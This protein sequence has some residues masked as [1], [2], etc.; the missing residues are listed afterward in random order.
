MTE[1]EYLGLIVSKNRIQISEEKIAALKAYKVPDSHQALMRFLGFANYLSAFVPHYAATPRRPPSLTDLLKGGSGKKTKFIWTASCQQAFDSLKDKLTK[2]VGLGIPDKRGDLVLETDA[3][4]VGIGAVLYQF[5]NGKLT[6][7]WFLSRKLNKAEKNYSSRDREALA[8]VYALV[9]ME[10]YLQ[11]KPFI[12]YSDHESLIYFQSQK[13]LKGRDW[14]WVEILA[15][16]SFEQRYRKGETMVAPDALSRAFDDRADPIGAWTE[17]E[18]TREARLHPQVD[19]LNANV[20]IHLRGKLAQKDDMT[21]VPVSHIKTDL[22][23]ADVEVT[24]KGNG[25][26]INK[27]IQ[28]LLDEDSCWGKLPAPVRANTPLARS[29]AGQDAHL[30]SITARVFGDLTQAIASAYSQD[31]E[32]K[33]IHELVQKP[34]EVLNSKE[35]SKCKN[36]SFEDRWVVIFYTFTHGWTP[37]GYS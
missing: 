33:E 36:F 24:K 1:M 27:E 12:L 34:L 19:T 23:N 15:N 25:I 14:R 22:A 35:R 7:L 29:L 18:H 16:Y 6:P 31:T 30:Y 4:G 17:L 9:K 21:T 37:V 8:V 2:A 3:S 20:P 26:D 32:L 10:A 28:I 5:T 11:Q 13:D